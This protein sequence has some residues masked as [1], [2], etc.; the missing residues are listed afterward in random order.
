MF[1]K[2]SVINE[3][4]IDLCRFLLVMISIVGIS[5]CFIWSWN[6]GR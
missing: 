1:P 6:I 2:Y 5:L 4:C 3:F